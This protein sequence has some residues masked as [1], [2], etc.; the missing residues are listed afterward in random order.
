MLKS[1]I[2]VVFV[3]DAKVGKTSMIK[4]SV[5]TENYEERNLATN[6][7]WINPVLVQTAGSAAGPSLVLIDTSSSPERLQQ[8]ITEI[9]NADSVI[10]IYD[11]SNEPTI[12]SLSR[13]WLPLINSHNPAVP[14]ILIGNKLDL[15][16]NDEE[17]YVKARV[18]RVI[19]VL[20]KDFK[21]G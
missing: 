9:K 16:V 15:V 17:R 3:G 18:R 19:G 7:S 12:G 21:A 14:V 8:T 1:S 11:M 10:L 20:F 6:E 4:N 13:H 5:E 2:K